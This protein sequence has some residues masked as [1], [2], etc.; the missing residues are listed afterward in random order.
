MATKKGFEGGMLDV[1]DTVQCLPSGC[2]EAG[3]GGRMEVRTW[4]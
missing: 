3:G 4:G 1:F 2:F